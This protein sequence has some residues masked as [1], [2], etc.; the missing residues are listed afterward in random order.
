MM[1]N[2]LTPLEL[3]RQDKEMIRRECAEKE[4]RLAEHWSYLS[5]HAGSLIF[6]SA[7]NAVLRHFGFGPKEKPKEGE[8]EGIVS[9]GLLSTL[10]AYYP[11]V[12]EFVQP[13]LIRFVIRKIKSIFSRKK[14]KKRR[15]DD[16]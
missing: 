9:S 11:I 8:S 3:L 10:T 16:H 12:W 13:M 14:K 4:D 2:E 1:K 15:D 7:V 6:Q 5:D